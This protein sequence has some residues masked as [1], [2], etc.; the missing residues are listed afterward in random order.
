MILSIAEQ[1][2]TF[3][4]TLYNKVTGK[5]IKRKVKSEARLL[6]A[7]ILIERLQKQKLDINNYETTDCQI[8]A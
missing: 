7:G 2:R 8:A 6:A 4:F 3:V 5:T 1:T